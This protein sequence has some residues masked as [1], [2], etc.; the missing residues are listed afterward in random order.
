[1]IDERI[2]ERKSA[3]YQMGLLFNQQPSDDKITAY[4]RALMNYSPDQIRHAFNQVVL[5]GTAF[6][7][8]LAEILKHLRPQEVTSDDIGNFVA[9]EVIQRVI[10]FGIYRIREAFDSLS[11]V[12]KK[13]VS[14]NTYI[15][16]EIANSNTD[17]LPTIRAQIRGM[18]KAAAEAHKANKA[19]DKL[20][21]LGIDTA[22][23]VSIG[24][25]ANKMMA[26]NFDGFKPEGA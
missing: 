3:V 12:S 21:R 19:H 10:D 15:L 20:E 17:Q 1:M 2:L 23:V 13:V 18:A 5:S 26:L 25:K 11:E 8:S 14:Q 4:A 22:N 7:P 6:F 16:Q 24:A 9:N